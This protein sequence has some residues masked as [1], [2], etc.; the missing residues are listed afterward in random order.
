MTERTDAARTRP[1]RWTQW[2]ALVPMAGLALGTVVVSSKLHEHAEH[3]R[4]IADLS[5]EIETLSTAQAGIV[6]RAFAKVQSD[7]RMGLARIRGEEQRGREGIY[8]RLDELAEMESA[9]ADF[10]ARLGFPPEPRLEERLAFT[11]GQFL[12]GVQGSLGQMGLNPGMLRRRL[13]FWDQN[14]G[15]FEEALR[16][17]RDR[18]DEI[19]AS[20]ASVAAEVGR[21]KAVVTLLMSC[22]FVLRIG[23]IRRRREREL[24]AERLA[25]VTRSEARFRRTNRQLISSVTTAFARPTSA[26]TE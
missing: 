25:A 13:D 8:A 16:S 3:R 12:G 23:A 24:E 15:A 11:A 14:Y 9:R 20:A 22:L 10:D 17:V 6:W 4:R 2:L 18:D 7:G 5:A 19:A 21:A 1:L 26:A